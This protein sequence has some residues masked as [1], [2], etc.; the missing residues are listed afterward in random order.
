MLPSPGDGLGLRVL[1]PRN[2]LGSGIGAG[3]PDG[4]GIVPIF[5]SEEGPMGLGKLGIGIGAGTIP[6][7]V[8]WNA[9]AIP[10]GV[11]G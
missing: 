11:V 10:A 9:G 6:E 3:V 7:G 5:G 4:G 2:M 8:G 1:L